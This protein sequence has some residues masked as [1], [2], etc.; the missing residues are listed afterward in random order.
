MDSLS[1]SFLGYFS[2]SLALLIVTPISRKGWRFVLY[3]PPWYSKKVLFLSTI[4]FVLQD[5]L[6]DPVSLR[7]SKW[8]LEQ[9]YYYPEQGGYFGVPLSNFIGWFLVGLAIIYCFQK[10]DLKM[11]WSKE[12]AGNAIMGPIFYFINMVFVLSVTF[13]IGEYWIGLMSL[14]VFSLL[15]YLTILKVR[16]VFLYKD[17]LLINKR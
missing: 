4:L 16:R 10:L 8:F 13:Y 14:S 17:E 2:Y 15:F 6:I 9:I 12:Y 5:V 11:G 7:D 1:Y 3:N